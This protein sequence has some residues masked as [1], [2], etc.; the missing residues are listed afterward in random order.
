[1]SYAALCAA[2]VLAGCASTVPLDALLQE[3]HDHPRER[4]H[5]YTDDE[6]QVT[7]IVVNFDTHA[8]NRGMK[9]EATTIGGF[10]ASTTGTIRPDIDNYVF[11]DLRSAGEVP[12]YAQCRIHMPDGKQIERPVIGQ[13]LTVT[14]TFKAYS[15]TPQGLAALLEHC[16]ID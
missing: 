11:V 2:A 10:I 7:G 5:T 3:G 16:D 8:V 1:M 15:R 12:G 9:V 4:E 6:I 13:S 14:G